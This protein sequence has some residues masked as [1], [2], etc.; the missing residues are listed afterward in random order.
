[1]QT[2]K[3]RY[4]TLENQIDQIIQRLDEFEKKYAVELSEVNPVYMKS[5]L[6]LVHY[7]AFRSFDISLLQDLKTFF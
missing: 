6:N 1:M 7:L 5:A 2:L 4:E 3:E